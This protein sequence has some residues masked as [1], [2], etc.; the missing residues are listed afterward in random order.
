M[1]IFGALK[2]ILLVMV[3]TAVSTSYGQRFD[4]LLTTLDTRYPQEKLHLQFD[5]SSYNPGETI[6]FKAYLFSNNL[7]SAISKNV[8]TE[9]IDQQGKVLQR[10]VAPVMNGGAAAAFDLPVDLDV[11]MLYVRSYTRWMLNFDSGFLYT[12]AIPILSTKTPAKAATALPKN[13]LEF[14]PEGGDLVTG[15]D[16]RVAFKATDANG[17]PFNV[18]GDIVNAK[19][20]KLLSFKSAHDGMGVFN[21]RPV[22]GEQYKAVWNDAAGKPQQTVLPV[23]AKSGVVLETRKIGNGIAFSV[24]RTEQAA[25]SISAVYI[26]AQMQQQLL[27]R[28]KASLQKSPVVSGMIPLQDIPAGIVQITVFTEKEEPLAERLVF[29]NT[30][31]YYFITDLNVPLKGTGKRGRN[32]IQIDVPD[33]IACNLSVAVTDAGVNPAT[34]GETDIFSTVLLTSDIKGY[35][36]NPGYYF[37]SE[38]D[39][40]LQHLDLVMMTNGWRRFRWEDALAGRFPNIVHLPEDYLSIEGKVN[41]LSK[42]ELAQKE[43]TGILTLENGSQQLLTLPVGQDGKFNIPGLFFYDTAKLYYQ[44]N[45]DKNKILSSK[46]LVDIRNNFLPKANNW[47]PTPDLFARVQK[48]DTAVLVKNKF[49][50]ERTLTQMEDQKRVQTLE[51]VEVVAKQKSKKEVMDEEYTSGLFRG[52][53]GYTF[54]TDD[55]PFARSA[56]SVLQY[57]Q[58][59]VP[60]LQITGSGTQ[61]SM[62]WRGGSP[63]LYLNEMIGDLSLIQNT[64]MTDVAMIKVFRPPFMGGFGGGAGGAIAVYTK[65]G[66]AANENVKGLDFARIPGYNPPKQFYSPDYSKVDPSHS[67]DDFRTTLYWNPFVIT[68]AN[69]RRLIFTFYNNDVSKKLRVV[70]EGVNIEGKLTRIEKMIE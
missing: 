27:Y 15:L 24:K 9:L 35:V 70:I 67:A 64:P 5:K 49:M 25:Q 68:D 45:N 62:A 40:V 46:A 56:M 13:L 11:P 41:G 8:Y 61:M 42:T 32:V 54:L 19:G 23:A 18:Q 53:D 63:S 30:Q 50:A 51:S 12:K 38:A 29:V 6:W 55:D 58:G 44:F 22:A 14:F 31:D 17:L 57:L 65:K 69:T 4:S 21:L 10:K 3:L 60:G 20:T 33:T 1:K 37:S 59:K 16:S 26:V 52:G 39:S 36:H 48:P 43:L 47:K 28:A 34:P 7:L 66:A 2:A